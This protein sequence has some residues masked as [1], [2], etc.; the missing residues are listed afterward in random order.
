MEDD[1]QH[2]EMMFENRA[3]AGRLLA[4]RVKSYSRRNGVLVM[5][6]PCGGPSVAAEIANELDL[7][8]D[9]LSVQRVVASYHDPWQQELSLGAVAQGGAC[10][11]NPAI[12]ATYGIVRQQV[13]A[14]VARATKELARRDA[15]YRGESPPP[16][17]A[18][19]TVILVDD[20]VKTGA[21]LR[22]AIRALRNLGAARIVVAVPVGPTQACEEL[23]RL[24]DEMICLVENQSF[25]KIH[26]RYNDFRKITDEEVRTLVNLCRRRC[27]RA[28]TA[29]VA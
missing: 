7:P 29:K 13:E 27:G 17:I 18:G 12:I 9:V 21:T 15:F 1:L 22:A 26:T 23:K 4:E 5:A 20:G 6:I 2:P 19:Q 14:A 8:L 3:D 16:E 11:L 28:S 25:E 24:A 10:A